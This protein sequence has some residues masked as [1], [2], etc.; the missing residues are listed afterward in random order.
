MIC[1]EITSVLDQI[2]RGEILK[3]LMQLQ[4]E[5]G[6]SYLF[7]THD[8]ATVRVIADEVL[9][10]NRGKRVAWRPR[11]GDACAQASSR[12]RPCRT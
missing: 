9:V 10:M 5:T 7:I 6:V 2:I 4:R 12:G 8:I 11:G 3:R 1:D